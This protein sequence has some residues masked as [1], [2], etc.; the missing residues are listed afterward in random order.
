MRL[1]E[2]KIDRGMKTGLELNLDRNLVFENRIAHEWLTTESAAQYLGVSANA[3]RIM[4]HRRQIRSYKFGSRL[5][6][7]ADD[8][9]T[10]FTLKGV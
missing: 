7:K 10:L 6:F 2:E 3:L 8:C 1:G 5:R 4:V 9:R